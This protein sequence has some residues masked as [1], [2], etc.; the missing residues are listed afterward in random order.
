MNI[1]FQYDHSF[2]ILA[3]YLG[4]FER[5]ICI[6]SDVHD[7]VFTC[8][9]AT[10]HI[11]DGLAWLHTFASSLLLHKF[12]RTSSCCIGWSWILSIPMLFRFLLPWMTIYTYN[13][14]IPNFL[15]FVYKLDLMTSLMDSTS[16]IFPTHITTPST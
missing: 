12:V 5:P 3:H 2:L 11:S 14:F 9:V 6:V 7:S 13:F 8:I 1:L 4:L 16:S 15:S 10:S